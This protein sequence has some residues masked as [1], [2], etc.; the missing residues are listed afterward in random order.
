MCSN[1]KSIAIDMFPILWWAEKY[2]QVLVVW[3]LVKIA[4]IACF[5]GRVAHLM[6]NASLYC[7]RWWQCCRINIINAFETRHTNKQEK[8]MVGHRTCNDSKDRSPILEW[9]T[10]IVNIRSNKQLNCSQIESSDYLK[11]LRHY[12]HSIWNLNITFW[13]LWGQNLSDSL[14]S[15]VLYSLLLL[16]TV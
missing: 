6:S 2:D 16:L 14:L 11:Y 13:G 5:V 8:Q 15:S 1:I 3:A 4:F 7:W 9:C 12:L 10:T